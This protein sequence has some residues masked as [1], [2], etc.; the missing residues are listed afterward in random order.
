MGTETRAVEVQLPHSLVSYMRGA[1]LMRSRSFQKAT[2]RPF[3]FPFERL[4]YLKDMEIRGESRDPHT[5]VAL[6]AWDGPVRVVGFGF[7]KRSFDNPRIERGTSIALDRAID[8]LIRK[9]AL[10]IFENG[11]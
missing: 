2:K 6:T 10:G 3:P 7:A 11:S 5:M 8:D 9:M 1:Y 4:L